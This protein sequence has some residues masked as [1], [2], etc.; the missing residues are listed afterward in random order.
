MTFLIKIISKRSRERSARRIEKRDTD[1]T[2]QM[3]R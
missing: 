1:E 3:M 2:L